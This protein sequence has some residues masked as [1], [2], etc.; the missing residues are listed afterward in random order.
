MGFLTKPQLKSFFSF[1]SNLIS[2][3]TPLAIII[4]FLLILSFCFFIPISSLDLFP[5]KCIFKSYILPFLFNGNCPTSGLFAGCECPAC[6]MTHSIYH[7][8]HGDF[9]LAWNTN[10]LSFLV[11][12]SI[13]ILLFFNLNKIYRRKKEKIILN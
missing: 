12:S 6:G 13:I 1:F 11:I 10:K 4:N 8:L 2:F 3:G 5:I 7:I 9:S